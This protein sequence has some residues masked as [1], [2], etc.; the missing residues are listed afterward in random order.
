MRFAFQMLGM[1]AQVFIYK[2]AYEEVAVIVAFMPADHRVKT[3]IS[4]NFFKV[5]EQ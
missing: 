1:K 5:V 2:C 3:G 4:T